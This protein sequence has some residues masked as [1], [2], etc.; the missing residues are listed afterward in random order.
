VSGLDWVQ[1]SE[2]AALVKQEYPQSTEVERAMVA[3]WVRILP[4]TVEGV[5]NPHTIWLF[6]GGRQFRLHSYGD[7]R[8]EV[9]YFVLLLARALVA[10]VAAEAG[11]ES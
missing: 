11:G 2:L 5:E 4:I 8:G 6:I 3:R 10:M 1:G 7:T 9:A